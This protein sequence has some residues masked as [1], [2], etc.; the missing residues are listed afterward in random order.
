MFL[1]VVKAQ[2]IEDYKLRL[3]FN[4]GVSKVVDFSDKLDGKVF[5]PLKD[6]QYFKSFSIKY[7]TIEWSNGA[8]FAPEYL[9]E[10]GV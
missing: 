2:Y 3:F 1:E 10:V 6:I 8:D 5:A 9:F 4:S 7:N